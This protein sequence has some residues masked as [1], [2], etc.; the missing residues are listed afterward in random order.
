MDKTYAI[1]SP[2]GG[3]KEDMPGILIDDLY[4]P[5]SPSINVL[6]KYGAISKVKGRKKH[7]STQ[8]PDGEEINLLH[9]FIQTSGNEF[10]IA[11]TKSKIYNWDGTEWVDITGELIFSGDDT[12]FW[13]FTNYG[14][15]FLFTNGKDDVYKWSGTGNIGT[16]SG[17]P[18]GRFIVN[19]K[20]YVVIG[21][22]SNYPNRIAWSS[23]GEMENWTGGDS[24]EAIID[25]SERI[26][27]FAKTTDYLVIFKQRAIYLLRYVGG[28][29]PFTVDKRVERIGC[30]SPFSI[31]VL[32]NRVYFF[33]A[34]K[35]IYMFD[36][37]EAHNISEPIA[38][39][40]DN[41]REPNFPLIYGYTL[42]NLNQVFWLIPEG[43]T[44]RCNKIIMYDAEKNTWFK[45]EFEGNVMASGEYLDETSKT[46]AWYLNNEP[47]TS[48]EDIQAQGI[49]WNDIYYTIQGDRASIL[50][51][52]DGYVYRLFSTPTD[53]DSDFE[54]V[55][56][57]KKI[58]FGN[59]ENYKRILFI[60]HIFKKQDR[61]N[62]VKISVRLDDGLDF[63]DER[64]FE[65]FS[66]SKDE[67]VFLDHWCDYVAKTLQL[68]ISSYDFFDYVG[69]IFYYLDYYIL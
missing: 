63:Q 5:G 43:D 69:S 16:L 38:Q 3:F 39:T 59:I 9:N 14:D 47:D 2:A 23:V 64:E 24:G 19:F 34:N 27:G 40:L 32:N 57:S 61:S 54:G 45:F 21:Q 68:K 28:D 8:V 52:P 41:I 26:M 46:W 44:E 7:I 30:Y 60:R 49:I 42:E 51:H 56:V 62:T 10:F 31:V 15:Y 53:K 66:D 25:D 33:G 18:L 67:L 35:R 11:G 50:G 29:I 22:L 58:P 17:A 13:S 4:T 37:I 36:G 20:N 65:L 48:W 6:F 1:I 55:F 12:D